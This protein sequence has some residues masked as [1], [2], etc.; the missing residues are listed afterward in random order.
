MLQEIAPGRS[1][2][3]ATGY[4]DGDTGNYAYMLPT[5]APMVAS[6]S[7][8]AGLNFAA[9]ASAAGKYVAQAIAGDVTKTSGTITVPTG[10]TATANFTFP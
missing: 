8:P 1:V 2:E 3:I 7:P 10:G 5:V 6:Y 9:Y 4:V